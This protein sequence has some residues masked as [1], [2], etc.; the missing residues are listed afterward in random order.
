MELAA[1]ERLKMD[2]ATFSI[3]LMILNLASYK[4]MFKIS[5]VFVF[6]PDS[7]AACC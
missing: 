7:I 1:I 5:D 3:H 2:V 4:D 6:K